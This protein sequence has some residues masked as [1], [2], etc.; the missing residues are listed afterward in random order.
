MIATNPTK[1]TMFA[2]Q[3]KRAEDEA[4]LSINKAIKDDCVF[5]CKLLNI[6]V[7]VE[8]EIKYPDHLEMEQWITKLFTVDFAPRILNPKA[9]EAMRSKGITPGKNSRDLFINMVFGSD[10]HV[11]VGSFIPNNFDSLNI[12]EFIAN[13]APNHSTINI[14][15]DQYGKLASISYESDSPLKERDVCLQKIFDELKR[16]KIY[17]DDAEDDL[18]FDF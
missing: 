18:I 15:N 9:L 8:D 11:H 14:T 16:L 2:P 17:T 4:K 10:T 13:I 1:R 5:L 12:E 3:Y 6:S 7:V